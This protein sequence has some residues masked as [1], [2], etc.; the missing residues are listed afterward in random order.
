MIKRRLHLRDLLL[1]EVATAAVALEDETGIYDLDEGSALTSAPSLASLTRL[2]RIG[3]V[4]SSVVG[5]PLFAVSGMVGGGV[6]QALLAVR[7]IPSAATSH[8]F[9]TV[10]GTISSVVGPQLLRVFQGHEDE[11]ALSDTAVSYP[12]VPVRAASP[13]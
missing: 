11:A 13:G 9:F 7:D 5:P 8:S 4:V 10:G 6:G 2:F 3:D 1:A 12:A